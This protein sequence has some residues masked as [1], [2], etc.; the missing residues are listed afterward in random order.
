MF[1]AENLRT[2]RSGE[3][4]VGGGC[5]LFLYTNE[6]IYPLI[7]IVDVCETAAGVCFITL[8]EQF[9]GDGYIYEEPVHRE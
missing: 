4:L 3:I 1:C 2:I 5:T 9:G 6:G 7:K 8:P